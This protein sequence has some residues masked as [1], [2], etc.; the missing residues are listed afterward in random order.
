[1][2]TQ[3]RRSSFF[4]CNFSTTKTDSTNNK[5]KRD[6]PKMGDEVSRAIKTCNDTQ[7]VITKPPLLH[8]KCRYSPDDKE[9]MPTG[10]YTRTTDIMVYFKVK[11]LI[12]SIN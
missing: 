4:C 5:H 11:S 2:K 3:N 10:A 6:D 7:I 9:S 8:I 12:K 1:M